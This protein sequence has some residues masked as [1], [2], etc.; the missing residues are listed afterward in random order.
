M[1][2]ILTDASG[3]PADNLSLADFPELKSN[4]E[5]WYWVDISAPDTHEEAVI[6]RRLPST[7]YPS[8]KEQQSNRRPQ[9]KISARNYRLTVIVISPNTMKTHNLHLYVSGNLLIS[10]H[11]TNLKAINDVWHECRQ[12]NDA[13]MPTGLPTILQRLF[14]RLLE[15]YFMAAN[16]LE[17]QIDTLDVNLK[18][19]SIPKLNNRVFHIR[20]QL[21]GFRRSISPLQDILQRMIASPAIETS[22]QDIVY[23]RE[24][25]ENLSRLVHIIESNMEIT[26]DVRDSYLSLTSYRM[27][28]IMQTLTVITVIFMPLTFIVGIYGMNFKYMPE[29]NWRYG[30]YVV[31]VLMVG[32]AISMY[33]WFRRKGWFRD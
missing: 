2:R 20:H 6:N 31:M 18:G 7:H 16:A 22:D 27:N 5:N 4:A 24:F 17:D 32:I 14:D 28:S 8:K 11:D 12:V 19:E 3:S 10:R 26:S 13:S 25:S 30:Y 33:F 1:I 23:M 9:L 15:Q 21:L 29:L